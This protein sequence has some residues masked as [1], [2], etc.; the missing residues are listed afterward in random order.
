MK[1][2]FL[3]SSHKYLSNDI[4]FV[5]SE[6]CHCFCY[7]VICDSVLFHTLCQ[8]SAL[9]LRVCRKTESYHQYRQV[10]PAVGHIISTRETHP[11]LVQCLRLVI[12]TGE[13]YCKVPTTETWT[14]FRQV[15]LGWSIMLPAGFFGI[16]RNMVRDPN[17]TSTCFHFSFM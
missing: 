10:T 14:L 9:P 15:L 5:W 16:C 2:T 17:T 4:Q 1:S 3:D 6:F 13:A 7:D 8:M 11:L 12:R